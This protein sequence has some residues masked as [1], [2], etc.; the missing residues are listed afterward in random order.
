MNRKTT[1]V[2]VLR[3]IRKYRLWVI[4]GCGR[5]LGLTNMPIQ[6]VFDSLLDLDN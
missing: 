1:V 6:D 3:Y 5:F 4:R 2:K